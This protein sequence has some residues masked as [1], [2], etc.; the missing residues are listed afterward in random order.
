MNSKT[1]YQNAK[2]KAKDALMLNKVPPDAF[3]QSGSSRR[4]LKPRSIGIQTLVG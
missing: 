2:K 3:K 1:E 4:G